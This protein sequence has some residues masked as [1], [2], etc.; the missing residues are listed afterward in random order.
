MAFAGPRLFAADLKVAL[1]D[2]DIS[3]FVL[4][5]AGAS[6]VFSARGLTVEKITA[7]KGILGILVS[8]QADVALIGLAVGLD[9][10]EGGGPIK[11]VASLYQRFDTF[12]VSRFPVPE[13]SKIRN[14]AYT[15]SSIEPQII[16]APFLE[17]LKLDPTKLTKVMATGESAKYAML[18]AG[19]ADLFTMSSFTL[20]SKIKAEGKFHLIT[21]AELPRAGQPYDGLIATEDALKAKPAQVGKFVSAVYAALQGARTD[22]AGVVKFMRERYKYT[23]AQALAFYEGLAAAVSVSSYVPGKDVSALYER[24]MAFSLVKTTRPAEGFVCPDFAAKAVDEYRKNPAR[25]P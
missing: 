9:V 13:A 15:S 6:G 1:N 3:N 14:I 4:D 2:N 24:V 21:A 12:A 20:A 5:Y 18:E 23:P 11:A 8:K 7:K 19:Q 25:R 16:M 22:K 17:Y 10:F